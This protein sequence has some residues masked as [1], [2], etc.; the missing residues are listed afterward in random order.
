MELRRA[1]PSQGHINFQRCALVQTCRLHV[2]R[3]RR[4]AFL[5]GTGE[6]LHRHPFQ[7]PA[8]KKGALFLVVDNNRG[9]LGISGLVRGYC[10]ALW[11]SG[12]E[13]FS[14]QLRVKRVSAQKS[15]PWLGAAN[16][17]NKTVVPFQEVRLLPAAVQLFCF[18]GCFF[19]F[20]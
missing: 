5:F 19:F 18:F 17:S 3:V 20:F 11:L 8:K 14:R 4:G 9:C 7:F 2:C 15:S 10:A 6:I 16:T 1:C 13:T 12:A